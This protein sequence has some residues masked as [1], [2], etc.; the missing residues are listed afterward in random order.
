MR[1]K[2][3]RRLA[4]DALKDPVKLGERL[5]ADIIGNLAD[6]PIGIQQFRLG[7]LQAYARDVIGKPHASGFLKHL[8][9]VKHARAR[10]P[11]HL[12]QR[13][14]S[15]FVF[16]DVFARLSHHQGL[17]IFFFEHDLIT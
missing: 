17:G 9:K 11:G 3:R 7:I 15:R 1:A 10:G 13:K 2:L 8:A 4:E 16:R 12:R 5:E 6:P 14:H